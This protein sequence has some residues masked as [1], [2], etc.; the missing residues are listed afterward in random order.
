MPVQTTKKGN[1]YYP[2]GAQVAL[3]ATGES[4]FTDVGVIMSAVN[5][6]L[7]YDTNVVNTA[8]ADKLD[9]QIRNM[10]VAGSFTLGNLEPASIERLSGGIIE[11][12]DTAGTPIATIPDQDIASG[13]SENTIYPLD[14]EVSS[15]D[16]TK[17]RTTAKP[18]I[19][20]VNLDP[21]G[22]PEALTE[23]DD[24]LIVEYGGAASGWGITF[25][26]VNIVKA[27]PTTYDIR[28]D[29]GSNTPIASSTLYAGASTVI[30]NAV[31]MQITHTD[32]NGKIRRLTINSADIDSGGIAFNFKGANEDG[33][34][35]MGIAFT[36][37][38]DTSLTSGRQLLSMT[39]EDG[40][41]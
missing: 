23:G 12:V 24:Y 26:T 7:N 13:W 14:M 9:Q 29:Y 28:I 32:D 21:D 37:K 36:G 38:L 15:S 19:T 40:A 8:N 31:A 35:E 20:S 30:M 22:T 1:I 4:V 25:Q 10:T 3:K 2:D 16:S 17:V 5:A 11:K 33:I 27:S 6:T 18:T 39:I 34:E 41:A